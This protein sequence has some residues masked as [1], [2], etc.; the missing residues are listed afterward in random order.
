MES[1]EIEN[2]D[3]AKEY[4]VKF[5]DEDE[6]VWVHEKYMS[7]EVV[8]DY[9]DNLEYA[10][11]EKILD[12]RN[13]GD[14]RVAPIAVKCCNRHDRYVDDDRIRSS[15]VHGTR[16]E[17]GVQGAEVA[18]IE[19]FD[20]ETLAKLGHVYALIFLF[21]WDA[22]IEAEL[23]QTRSKAEETQE[24]DSNI[25]FA[26]QVIQNAC[27]TQAIVNVLMNITEGRFL[28][29]GGIVEDENVH[30]RF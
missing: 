30:G 23:E 10:K 12:V 2:G 19:S 24:A 15:S 22:G 6:P 5:P 11:A 21:K 27:A 4:L 8:S 14:S 26:K 13:K 18:E 16:S 1:R 7:E 3:G 20:D 28:S 17:I 29:G 25:Y 9:Q